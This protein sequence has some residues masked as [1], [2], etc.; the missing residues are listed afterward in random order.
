MRKKRRRT[1]K[2][3]PKS[4]RK[5]HR[6]STKKVARLP[7]TV[8][9]PHD[10][11]RRRKRR[12]RRGRKKRRKRRKTRRKRCRKKCKKHS[13]VHFYREV[14]E[15]EAA[16]GH[17][18][19]QHGGGDPQNDMLDAIK[20]NHEVGIVQALHNGAK[21]NEPKYYLEP[22]PLEADSPEGRICTG[23][24][25]MRKGHRTPLIR[26][27]QDNAGMGII[28]QILGDKVGQEPGI[29]L[30]FKDPWYEP[31]KTALEIAKKLGNKGA[32]KKIKAR[33]GADAGEETEGGDKMDSETDKKNKF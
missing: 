1:R 28:E 18:H 25:V 4:A 11:G 20:E 6:R 3:R 24:T 2:N 30:K 14:G 31:P 27:I 5:V 26:A 15:A 21:V 9:G 16:E 32:I 33:G 23:E 8:L 12:T 22:K 13:K 7:L 17:E 29:D 10:G 19:C